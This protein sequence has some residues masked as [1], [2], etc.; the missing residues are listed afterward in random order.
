MFKELFTRSALT[1]LLGTSVVAY[2]FTLIWYVM[3]QRLFP[4]VAP[5]NLEFT[6]TWLTLICV[7]LTTTRNLWCWPTGVVSVLMFAYIFYTAQL[8]SSSIMNA[9]YYFPIQFYGWYQWVYGGPEKTPR[10]VEWAKGYER[11]LVLLSI[12]VFAFVWGSFFTL[13]TDAKFAYVDAAIFGTSI[14]AQWIMSFKRIESWY[15][16]IAVNIMSCWLYFSTDLV[17]I[18]FLYGLFI[19]TAIKGIYQ[20]QKDEAHV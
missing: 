19:L 20:W 15:C 17:M 18:G 8:Y 2:V 5:G 9:V 13:Y 7:W 12:P 10:V 4:D 14:V 16:W 1:E 11:V 6:G 3:A